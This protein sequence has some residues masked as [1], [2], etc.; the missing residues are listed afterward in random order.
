M[1][2][3]IYRFCVF[4]DWED[5]SPT[6]TYWIDDVSFKPIDTGITDGDA[7]YR[8]DE[9]IAPLL[10]NIYYYQY[11][12]EAT[13][14]NLDYVLPNGEY[15]RDI[16][17][18][19]RFGRALCNKSVL[20]TGLSIAVDKPWTTGSFPPMIYYD[21]GTFSH[22]ISSASGEQIR[23]NKLVFYC[24][25]LMNTGNNLNFNSIYGDYILGYECKDGV[26]RT[27]PSS[28]SSSNIY[29]CIPTNNGV[30]TDICMM[31]YPS[32]PWTG[33]YVT[34]N[35]F[36]T[37]R[38][39]VTSELTTDLIY[40]S[41]FNS[42]EIYYIRPYPSTGA[43]PISPENTQFFVIPQSQWFDKL[44]HNSSTVY[45]IFGGDVFPNYSVYKDWEYSELDSSGNSV[46]IGG[47]AVGF[48]SFNRTNAALR[49]GRYPLYTLSNYLE[50]A[51]LTDVAYDGDAYGYRG[52]F[53]PRYPFQNSTSFNPELKQLTKLGT[54]IFYSEQSV[55]YDLAG[56]NRV[57]LPLSRKDLEATYGD[58]VHME[59]LLGF[60]ETGLLIVWQPQR[61]TAQ[62]FD[63]TANI[64]SSTGELLIGNGE[65]M[66]R[67][68]A[69]FTEYG[70][71]HK[72]TIRKGQN[73]TGKDVVFWACF[74]KGAIMRLG[75]DGTADLVGDINSLLTNKTFLALQNEFNNPDTPAHNY[76][77]H[78]VW[79]NQTKEYILTLTLVP[80][81]VSKRTYS[82]GD[83]AI[84]T[85]TWG[86]E[87]F[88]VVY[89]SIGTN[90]LQ[91]PY[92]N[93]EAYSG[94]DNDVFQIWTLVWNELDNKFKTFRTFNPKIYGQFNNTYVSSHPNY[95]DKI[96]EHNKNVNEA[97]FYC[98]EE[99]TEIEAVTNPELYRIEGAGIE[100]ILPFPFAPHERTKF[101]VKIEGKNFEIVG[102]GT[103]YL[104]MAS[105]DND[106]IL[107][108]YTWRGFVYYICNSQDP[109]IE[110]V[111]NE[112]M[113]RYVNF[114]LKNTQADD[115]LKRVEYFAGYDS[116]GTVTTQS[117]TNKEEEEFYNGESNVQIK[118][119][120]TN[121]P[122]D[123]EVG[124]NLV[125]GKWMKF[126]QFWRWGK[127][128]RVLTTSV[129]IE[130]TEYK[131][132]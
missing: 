66:G 128:N 35:W 78:A 118:M 59:I 9:Q 96:Y 119:D 50:N 77:C 68:G 2:W 21:F 81:T 25:D 108:E 32:G 82:N 112:S 129:A 106:D 79:N 65:I 84:G 40:L 39:G 45:S 101:V 29:R 114:V 113:P 19:I 115:T 61:T 131:K 67:K 91:P 22:T 117:F 105:I 110:G 95:P 52:S 97:L 89:K 56:G 17:K 124:E 76:G 116:L 24:P 90:S 63:N 104:Q 132:K 87:N 125:E 99:R 69:D 64:K 1:P 85:E 58:I 74:R 36:I 126:K 13:N 62:Y 109:Y 93:W 53:T 127:K 103:D 8:N 73:P 26:V 3:D 5:G 72:W 86:F 51:Y 42:K 54:S 102:S 55:S 75:A 107:P 16:I 122:T 7:S 12:V 41:D 10:S 37:V 49:S 88:P 11:I 38:G 120:T 23:K 44:T 18:D 100:S 15:L 30:T 92:G 57:W 47:N 60:S 111:V 14:I 28:S 71:E 34:P 6:S 48:F 83:W 33:S 98:T 20:A 123:N 4:I 46:N 31:S 80:A 94:Y 27:N 130:E 70:C 43:Y 121:N